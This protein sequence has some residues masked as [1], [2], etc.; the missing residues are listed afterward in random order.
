M[1]RCLLCADCGCGAKEGPDGLS[2]LVDCMF[3]GRG[4]RTENPGRD[5]VVDRLDSELVLCL[6][7]Y[8][9]LR[10]FSNFSP[11]GVWVRSHVTVD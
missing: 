3:S 5:G 2:V 4:V 10:G 9:I 8:V 6:P 11:R 1:F 7:F